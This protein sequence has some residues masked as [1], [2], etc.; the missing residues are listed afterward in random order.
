MDA[1]GSDG[2]AVDAPASDAGPTDGRLRDA[3]TGDVVNEDAAWLDATPADTA[4]NDTGGDCSS[5]TPGSNALLLDPS[6]ENSGADNY[7][8]GAGS[9]LI[10]EGAVLGV[11]VNGAAAGD[12]NGSAPD[13]GAHESP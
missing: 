9:L 2:S 13:L 7:A 8:L 1:G 10:D 6:Y 12:F 3:A 11:D 4:V 5:C